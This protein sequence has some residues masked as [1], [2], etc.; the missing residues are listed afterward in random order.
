MGSVE[1][2]DATEPIAVEET[3]ECGV[4][5]CKKPA[6]KD[7]YSIDGIVRICEE[8]YKIN[9]KNRNLL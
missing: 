6:T 4:P 7:Y 9:L 2:F 1:S 5:G 8:H 3:L